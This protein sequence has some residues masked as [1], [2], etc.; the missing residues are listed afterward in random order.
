MDLSP[1]VRLIKER[2]GLFI[3]GHR[4]SSLTQ[5]IQERMSTTGLDCHS[6]YFNTLLEDMEETHRLVDLLTNNETYFFRES[7]HFKV[8]SDRVIPELLKKRLGGEKIRVL[9]AGCSTGEEPYSLVI[10][11]IEKFGPKITDSIKVVGCD[12]NQ[13]A[14]RSAQ[15][16]VYKSHSFRNVEKDFKEKF[17]D[18]LSGGRYQLKSYV[19]EGV[20]FIVWNMMSDMYPHA[21][22]NSD[23]IFYRNV[24]IYFEPDTRKLVFNRLSDLLANDGYLFL[25]SSETFSH[26]MGSLFLEDLEGV[27]LYRKNADILTNDRGKASRDTSKKFVDV[28]PSRTLD[29]D[30]RPAA[31][32]GSRKDAGKL[33]IGDLQ[34]LFEKALGH[35][36]NKE[37]GKA[38][39]DLDTLLEESPAFAKAYNLKASILIHQQRMDEAKSHCLKTLELDEWNLESHLLLG[40]IAKIEGDEREAL[41]HFKGALYIDPRCWLAHMYL[42]DI[43]NV[44]GELEGA[45]REYGLAARLLKKNGQENENYFLIP[46]AFPMEHVI[47]MCE[48]NIDNLKQRLS[49]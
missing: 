37:N 13:K 5:A 20:E 42:G 30:Y 40:L 9:S 24:S 21:L 45:C 15:E 47:H 23:I 28:S 8:F 48:H 29:N 7:Q 19:K 25:S 2:C 26:S 14:I 6:R 4:H 33:K 3:R 32:S 49:P 18:R 35:A 34:T 31:Q 12:I 36:R 46:L 43:H 1:F 22:V 39:E 10:S 27:F 44:L 41:T 38:L 17:F 16:G 11:L